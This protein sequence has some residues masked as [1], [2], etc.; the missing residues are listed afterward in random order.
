MDDH[1]AAVIAAIAHGDLHGPDFPMAFA[2]TNL[3]RERPGCRDHAQRGDHIRQSA[4]SSLG[5]LAQSAGDP[6]AQAK[7]SDIE[8]VLAIDPAKID[9]ASLA[10]RD[11]RRGLSHSGKAESTS[12]V[13]RR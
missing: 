9:A 10:P 1:A 2:A 3:D 5:F 11:R 7:A 12:Q 8:K 4:P 13:V 6:Y